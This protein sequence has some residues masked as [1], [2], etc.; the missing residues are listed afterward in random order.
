M[1]LNVDLLGV[2]IASE[3]PDTGILRASGAKTAPRPI[4]A[5]PMPQI[6]SVIVSVKESICVPY[7]VVK[8]SANL[9]WILHD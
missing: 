2:P 3:L 4:P 1:A 7:Y 8:E 5:K 6:V 9:T